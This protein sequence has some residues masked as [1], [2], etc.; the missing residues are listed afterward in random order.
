MNRKTFIVERE[1][2]PLLC[3][4]DHLLSLALYDDVFASKSLSNISNIFRAK[5]P[6]GRKSLQ[7][8]IKRSALD[9]PVFREP[10]RAADGYRT[11]PTR[12]LR[13]KTWLRY[14][15]RLGLKSGLEKAF[16]EYCA[17]RGLINAINSKSVLCSVPVSLSS[18]TE[19]DAGVARR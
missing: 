3:L 2:N 5:I 9:V 17:R 7:L 14:L 4:L 16:T 6:S 12:P 8:K 18:R 13:S 11:S 1:E 15:K 10:G 19:T